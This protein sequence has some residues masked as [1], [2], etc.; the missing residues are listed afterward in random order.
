MWK[1]ADGGGGVGRTARAVFGYLPLRQKTSQ[2]L[3]AQN[4]TLFLKNLWFNRMSLQLHR[5]LAGP[6]GG[7]EGLK[8]PHSHGWQLV[9]AAGWGTQLGLLAGSLGSLPRGPFC[10]AGWVSS[11]RGRRVPRKHS[12]NPGQKLQLPEGQALEVT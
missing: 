1:E 6:L 10:V 9:L 11:Q 12:Q 2:N 8:C 3:G 4:T 5:M 7:L